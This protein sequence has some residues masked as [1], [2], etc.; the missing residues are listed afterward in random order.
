MARIVVNDATI[1]RRFI[2][3]LKT[4][5]NKSRTNAGGYSAFLHDT[6][7]KPVLQIEVALSIKDIK[8]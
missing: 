5:L 8:K 6:E 1:L 2:K 4:A 3:D 7:N